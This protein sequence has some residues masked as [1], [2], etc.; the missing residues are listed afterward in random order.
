MSTISY[1]SLSYSGQDHSYSE[2]GRLAGF[3][4]NL[5]KTLSYN[6]LL[7]GMLVA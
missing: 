5:H 3:R 6:D 4:P 7:A 2:Q 1:M